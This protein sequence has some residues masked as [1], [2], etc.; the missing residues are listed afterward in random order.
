MVVFLTILSIMS[1]CSSKK[2]I[3]RGY[4]G[5]KLNNVLRKLERTNRQQALKILGEPAVAGRC[6]FICG[7]KDVYRMIYPMQ[8]T[9]K[10]YLEVT[11]N[12]DQKIDCVIFDF[13]PDKKAQ[14]FIFKKIKKA[15]DCNNK[16]GEIQFLKNYMMSD[17]GKTTIKKD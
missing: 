16:D 9:E 8:D 12:T 10:F 3:I 6:K 4:S 14:K 1:S 13:Y 7:P 11:A 2:G 17:A 15:K 5:H